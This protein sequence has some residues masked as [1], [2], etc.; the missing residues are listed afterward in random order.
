MRFVADHDLHIHSTVSL[1]CHDSEQTP[2]AILNY[3]KKNK[4]KK[5]CLTNHF[6]DE[7]VESEVQWHEAHRFKNIVS[8]LPLPQDSNVKFHLG[9]ETDM[10]YNNVLGVSA[11][12]LDFLDFVIVATTHLHLAGNTVKN[13]IET[14]QEAADL[15]LNKLENLLAKKLP[16]HKIGIAHL[17][18]GHILKNQT[19]Q[20]ISLL[21][22][23]SLYSVFSDCASKGVGIELNMK[24]L[25]SSEEEKEI[26]LKPYY[27]AK[28]CGCKFYLGS[29]AHK[30][31]A[32]DSAKE[33]F[34]NIITLLDLKE[35]DKFVL[36]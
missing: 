19:P 21:S 13:K 5:I 24:T 2:E 11:E 33:N 20:V 31:E 3:A 7:T 9:A 14:P 1:C 8:V 35:T 22:D 16:W 4:F 23:K 18:C 30:L 17:T 32:L 15:W 12:K 25:F 6:W 28:D 26:M 34:E 36:R 27:I 29:D 10:D